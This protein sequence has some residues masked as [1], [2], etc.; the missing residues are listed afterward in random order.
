MNTRQRFEEWFFDGASGKAAARNDDGAYKYM[1]AMQAWV[2]WQAG[3]EDEREEIAKVVESGVFL[4]D[5]A[6]D[7]R[8]GKACAGAIRKRSNV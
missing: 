1:P 2:A 7:A 5:D 3:A 8:F 4:H 6:P